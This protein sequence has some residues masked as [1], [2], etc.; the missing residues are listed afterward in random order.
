MITHLF[1]SFLLFFS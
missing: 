1:I